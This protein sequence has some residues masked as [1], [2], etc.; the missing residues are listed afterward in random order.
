M[1]V[2]GAEGGWV[3]ILAAGK[4]VCEFGTESS[5]ALLVGVGKEQACDVTGFH[6]SYDVWVV[7]LN[8]HGVIQWS[9][10][11]GGSSLDVGTSCKQTADGGYLIAGSTNSN[12]G[13]VSGQHNFIYG[14]FWVVKLGSFGNLQ[15]QRCYG[16]I[17]DDFT[18]EVIVT[19]DGGAYIFGTTSSNDGDVTGLIGQYAHGNEPSH[20]MSYLYNY[21][22]KPNK[23]Q[24]KVYQ[25][26]G[27]PLLDRALEG[28]FWHMVKQGL[29]RRIL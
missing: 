19:S 16:G 2:P 11:L 18:S 28:V 1:R 8:S 26:V 23:T 14:D 9:K 25:S 15:W 24:E 10:C 17:S 29:V 6:G 27:K 20:H 7:K 21:I 22:G 3:G 5:K 13:N 12:D 4:I